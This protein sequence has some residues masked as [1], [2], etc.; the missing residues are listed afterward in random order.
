MI[1]SPEVPDPARDYAIAREW[2]DLI[3][4]IASNWAR[5]R[6]GAAHGMMS[7]TVQLAARLA[8]GI[9]MRPN[10]FALFARAV[11]EGLDP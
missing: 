3:A 5:S 10:D 7:A 11:F 4:Q 8:R 9:G 2:Y 6:H 1:S